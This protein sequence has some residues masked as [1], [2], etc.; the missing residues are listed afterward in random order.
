METIVQA[1]RKN[2]QVLCVTESDRELWFAQPRVTDFQRNFPANR[3]FL[4]GM[5]LDEAFSTGHNRYS[6]SRGHTMLAYLFVVIAVAFRFIPHPWGFTPISASL[7]FFGAKGS[8]RMLWLPVALMMVC[9]IVLTKYV[10]GVAMTW[11]QWVTWAWY[12]GILWLGTRLKNNQKPVRVVLA[13]LTTSVSFF[14]ISNF[15]VWAATSLYPH[16]L[17]GLMM[18]YTIGLPHFQRSLGGDLLFT[19]LMFASPFAL[20]WLART[21]NKGNDH[22]AAA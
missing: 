4:T 8:R 20:Q 9:D 22:I 2:Y 14:V 5:E 13:S 1:R 3:G 17:A 19:G 12:A 7:L 15:A 6:R 11:D 16:N 10:Y 21:G 18:S